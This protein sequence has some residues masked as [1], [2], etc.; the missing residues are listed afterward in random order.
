MGA[1][2]IELAEYN[3]DWPV[4]FASEAKAIKAVLGANAINIYHIGSTAVPG[5]IAKP[6]IDILLQVADLAALTQANPLTTLHY[7][8]RGEYGIVGRRYFI[9]GDSVR[10]HHLHA[11]ATDDAN[12]VRHLAFRDFLRANPAAAAEYSEIK[13]HAARAC[14]N[15]GSLY[16]RLKSPFLA[17]F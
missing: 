2:K 3:P 6:V 10:T 7:Q 4:L 5:M 12:I 14:N 1:R 16:A 8:A 13:R 9:K 15:N 11:F 17:N